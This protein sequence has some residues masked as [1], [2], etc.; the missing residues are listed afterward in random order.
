MKLHIQFLILAGFTIFS[1]SCKKKEQ[2]ISSDSG[3]TEKNKQARV[4]ALIMEQDKW[5]QEFWTAK[6]KISINHPQMN[7]SFNMTLRAEKNKQ[8]WFS[9]NAFGLMEVARGLVDKDSVRVWD[10][11]NNRCMIGSLD[12]LQGYVPIPLGLGQLQHFLMGRVF[13]DSLVAGKMEVRGDSSFV[14]GQQGRINFNASIWQKYLLHKAMATD[15]QLEV[16]LV[17]QNFKPISNTLIPFEKALSSSQMENGKMQTSGLKIEFSKFEFLN[18]KP[19]FT[20]E[21][22]EDCKKQALK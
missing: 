1:F 21:L 16:S 18:T 10:K 20:L 12:V 17:N 2:D 6:A 22:P 3:K 11:F 8:I 5:P 14:K 4:P 7:V 15:S 13:W 19:D 9:A